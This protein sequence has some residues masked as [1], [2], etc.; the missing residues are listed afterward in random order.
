MSDTNGNGKQGSN[1]DSLGRF[2]K[3]VSGNPRGVPP[4]PR[5]STFVRD[6]LRALLAEHADTGDEKPLSKLDALLERVIL[7]VISGNM[8]AAKLVLERILPAGV[9]ADINVSG[10][11]G[12]RVLEVFQAINVEMIEKGRLEGPDGSGDEN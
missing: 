3:G 6:R 1:R 8:H 4:G 2:P 11:T 12:S 10:P 5:Y 9:V 7:E